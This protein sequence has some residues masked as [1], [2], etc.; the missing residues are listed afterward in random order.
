M[1]RRSDAQDQRRRR[2]ACRLDIERCEERNLLSSGLGELMA[3]RPPD[4]IP[5]KAA[6]D[7]ML[8]TLASFNGANGAY[9]TAGLVRRPA[10]QPLRHD[11]VR[12]GQR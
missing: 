8:T 1:S 2:R 6:A 10:G 9:T 3:P 4:T 12:R 11:A 5:P 7:F